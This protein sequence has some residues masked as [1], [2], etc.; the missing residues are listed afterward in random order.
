MKKLLVIISLLLLGSL[1]VLAEDFSFIDPEDLSLKAGPTEPGEQLSIL[2]LEAMAYP[3]VIK[4]DRT[5]SLGLQLTSKVDS[6]VASFDF[7]QDQVDLSSYDGMSWDGIYELSD[8]VAPGLHI[9]RYVVTIA[10]GSIQRTLNFLVEKPEGLAEKEDGVALGEISELKQ[11]PLTVSTTCSAIVDGMTR[12]LYAGERVSGIAKVPWY[13]IVLEDGRQG[14]I[15]Q[16]MVQEPVDQYSALGYDAY[17]S[18]DYEAA[19]NYYN[20]AV[21]VDPNF[22]RGH[23]WLAKT[24]SKLGNLDAAFHAIKRAV[25]L[26]DRDMDYKVLATVLAQKYFETA[27]EKFRAKRYHEAI[28]AY[29]RVLDLKSNSFRSWIDLGRSYQA[30]GFPYEARA[31]WREA[32]KANPESQETYA[33]LNIEFDPSVL[34]KFAQKTSP[35]KELV[36]QKKGLPPAL[37][38]DSLEIILAGSTKKGTKIEAAIKSVITLTKSLGTPVI[39]KGWEITKKGEEFLVSYVCEQG[40]G[41]LEAFEW[42]VDVDTK[43]FVA[44][45][46]NARTLMSRW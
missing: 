44:Y 22:A 31:A 35:A 5:L 9:V 12:I 37:A 39:E 19:V 46:D 3:K 45:N 43:H 21:T 13:K 23:F 20:D 32:L 29:Q 25:A 14:W 27:R 24:Y 40:M 6:V 17:H 33:L 41:A 10:Q 42:K 26:N 34:T 4:E 16:T 2:W 36:E 28:V 15:P 11:W 18:G 8:A 38:D 7:N 30:L 1:M